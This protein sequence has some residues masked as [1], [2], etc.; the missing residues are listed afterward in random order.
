MIY[1]FTMPLPAFSQALPFAVVAQIQKSTVRVIAVNSSTSS[2]LRRVASGFTWQRASDVITSFHVVAGADSIS[3]EFGGASGETSSESSG[4]VVRE[5]RIKSIDV[6][7]DLVLLEVVN[8]PDWA[9][10]FDRTVAPSPGEPIWL[11]GFPEATSG[12][13]SVRLWLS[14][15]APKTLKPGLNQGARDDLERLGFPSVNLPVLHVQGPLLHGDSGSPI[16]DVNGALAAVGNGGLRD[17]AAQLGWGI[18]AE[19]VLSLRDRSE[20]FSINKDALSTISTHFFSSADKFSQ[21][22]RRLSAPTGSTLRSLVPPA[23]AIPLA[24]SSDGSMGVV[25]YS[26]RPFVL[27]VTAN[28][29]VIYPQFY[30]GLG[31]TAA[32]S[33]DGRYLAGG[34]S[35]GKVVIWDAVSGRIK[36]TLTTELQDGITSIAFSH[37]CEYIAAGTEGGV[38]Y[39]W[40]I[41]RGQMVGRLPHEFIRN[42]VLTL[43]FSPND[44]TLAAGYWAGA[45]RAW[46]T[47]GLELVV[48]LPE[49]GSVAGLNFSPDGGLLAAAFSADPNKLVIWNT[50][51]WEILLSAEISGS[52]GAIGFSSDGKKVAVGPGGGNN[53]SV[54][55]IDVSNGGAET[56]A[57]SIDFHGSNFIKFA[58]SEELTW[59]TQT[60]GFVLWNLQSGTKVGGSKPTGYAVDWGAFKEDGSTAAWI[61]K[62]AGRITIFDLDKGRIESVLGG[63]EEY[64]GL[65]DISPN[66]L[67]LAVTKISGDIQIVHA[68][69]GNLEFVIPSDGLVADTR[70]SRD[71]RSIAVGTGAHNIDIWNV[72]EGTLKRRI[73]GGSDLPLAWEVAFSPDRQTLAASVERSHHDGVDRAIVRTWVM[74][75]GDQVTELPLQAWNA[76]RL[77][78][79]KDGNLLATAEPDEK[80]IKIWNLR[81]LGS[82]VT[83]ITRFRAQEFAFSPIGDA[84]AVADGS[85]L[86]LWDPLRGTFKARYS[87]NIG[88]IQKV[89]YSADGRSIR[90]F[91]AFGLTIIDANTGNGFIHMRVTSPEGWIAL[92]DKGELLGSREALSE[93][94]LIDAADKIIDID[95][96]YISRHLN[97]VDP[98]LFFNFR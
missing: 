95:E 41:V 31:D 2:S 92:N 3:V 39:L 49:L 86:E 8:P 47:N 73:Q 15:I 48:D 24:L 50:S 88:E 58:S 27:N 45:I 83:I 55:V 37:D 84:I 16:F 36:R 64:D 18:P 56:V 11:A 19:R 68:K 44:Q 30:P 4:I 63:V 12:L 46:S 61:D 52:P 91:G 60:D 71:S 62:A 28:E 80:R 42:N 43:A 22:T 81:E 90:V 76:G 72:P 38:V 96:S 35:D 20:A 17:G 10:W 23:D 69:S 78:Y 93:V 67:W 26:G 98:S 59:A 21:P 77:T 89:A 70:F 34:T 66:G 75:T 74:D 14:D 25:S 79:S 13:R 5:A 85:L 94:Q 7:G 40:N 51:N 87:P 97:N 6:E 82:F 1:L 29:V 53:S 32:Y 9:A 65:G 54:S 57:T 33:A